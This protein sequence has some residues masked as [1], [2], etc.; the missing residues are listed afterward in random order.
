M[1]GTDQGA[2]GRRGFNR[3]RPTA[4]RKPKIRGP[5]TITAGPSAGPAAQAAAEPS[6]FASA[7]FIVVWEVTRACAL[8]CMHCRAEAIPHRHPAELTTD[9]GKRL[10][11]HLGTICPSGFRPLAAGSVHTD[12]L[13]HVYREHPLFRALR[14]PARLRG[15]CELKHVCGGS[16]ARAY[17]ASGDRSAETPPARTGSEKYGRDPG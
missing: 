7:P 13:V 1:I 12:D 3:E 9:E 17:A 10:I 4:E 16:R 11:D 2:R 14:D 15:R 6:A 8:A 5:S